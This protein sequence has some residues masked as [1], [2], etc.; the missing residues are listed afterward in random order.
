MI[1]DRLQPKVDQLFRGQSF[2]CCFYGSLLS[3]A[4]ALF[5]DNKTNQEDFYEDSFHLEDPID[6]AS[7]SSVLQQLGEMT[8]TSAL[9]KD[10]RVGMSAFLI[11]EN[12]VFDLLRNKARL[13]VSDS[14]T[15]LFMKNI[16][17]YEVQNRMDIHSVISTI[18]YTETVQPLTG[19]IVV[20]FQLLNPQNEYVSRMAVSLLAP[21]DKIVPM[22]EKL[23]RG[24]TFRY[25]TNGD[26]TSALMTLSRVL[27]PCI[28]QPFRDNKLTLYLRPFIY[29]TS[30]VLIGCLPPP[31]DSIASIPTVYLK[32]SV[33]KPHKITGGNKPLSNSEN[34]ISIIRYCNAIY[35]SNHKTGTRYSL[36]VPLSIVPILHPD[37]P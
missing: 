14:G 22:E 19:H 25:K 11:Q 28:R 23:L 13:A 18:K 1:T 35:K 37:V 4:A 33:L 31:E 29:R 12:A 3:P 24:N 32:K 9:E 5:Y 8:L 2:T 16:T 30:F 34:F 20:I 17:C 15:I 36:W 7:N 21:C 10:W 27:T 6:L 26:V